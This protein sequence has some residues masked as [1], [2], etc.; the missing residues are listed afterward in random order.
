MDDKCKIQNVFVKFCCFGYAC[1]TMHT[2]SFEWIILLS[3]CWTTSTVDACGCC[4]C[5]GRRSAASN[6][7]TPIEWKKII[8]LFNRENSVKYIDIKESVFSEYKESVR[9]FM[10]E[11]VAFNIAQ[12][13]NFI[14]YYLPLTTSHN[15]RQFQELVDYF[16]QFAGS[17]HRVNDLHQVMME[18]RVMRERTISLWYA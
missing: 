4:D 13:L 3:L 5:F 10:I 8:A 12:W 16:A 9:N 14:G 7:V 6:K 1:L 15:V 11:S 17:I 2:R 18:F